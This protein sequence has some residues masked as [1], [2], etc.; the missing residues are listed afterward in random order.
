VSALGFEALGFDLNPA[1][2]IV[3]KARLLDSTV[4][5]SLGSLLDDLVTKAAKTD[6][7]HVEDD[8]LEIWFTRGSA[9]A[10]RRFDYAIQ[11]LLID[12]REHRAL[13]DHPT[14]KRVSSLAAFFYVAV[15]RVLR[16]L[17]APFRS[18][19]P[20]WIKQPVSN[21]DRVTVRESRLHKLLREQVKTMT[22]GLLAPTQATI[23][24]HATI[25]RAGSTSLPI[26]DSSVDAVI[27]SP[28]Y[29]TRIDYVKKTS[30][31]LAFLGA[32]AA[33]IKRLR[34]EMIGTPTIHKIPVQ[35]DPAWGSACIDTL[36]VIS[37][38]K[39]YASKSYYWK[40]FVQYFGGLYQSLR[41]IDRT[42]KSAGQCILVVQDS[43]YKDTHV[44][45][46]KIIDEMT[47]GLGWSA[48]ARS[49]FPTTKTI[50]GLNTHAIKN[51]NPGQATETVLSFR[52]NMRT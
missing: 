17:L 44:D 25:D 35:Q 28:P 5:G 32:N 18:A 14:L 45:L 21:I 31:E 11:T 2:V 47:Q 24:R 39:S 36:E 27:S 3:A 9:A 30:P 15:F 34:H 7:G 42:L 20:T 6:L 46:A 29:C 38:H 40:T 37:S 19:N 22:T 33:A 50:V 52:K 49:D 8:P 13:F 1:M 48:I 12:P 41:E 16:K 51:G 43:Y 10:L 4:E 23:P 26:D